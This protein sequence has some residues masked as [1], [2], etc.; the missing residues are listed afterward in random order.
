MDNSGDNGGARGLVGKFLRLQADTTTRAGVYVGVLGRLH[1]ARG[2]AWVQ[3]GGGG[4]YITRVRIWR[5]VQ[6][7]MGTITRVRVR[8]GSHYNACGYMRGRTCITTRDAR[9][10]LTRARRH[11]VQ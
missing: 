7:T 2:Y 8:V 10:S 5:G 11:T 9:G 6:F 3:A 4:G 1:N